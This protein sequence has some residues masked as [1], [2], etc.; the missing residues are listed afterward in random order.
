MAQVSIDSGVLT[1]RLSPADKFWALHGDIHLPIEHITGAAVEDENGWHYLWKLMG[2]S[3]PGIKVAGTFL[4]GG[5]LAFCDFGDGRNC[6]VLDTTHETYKKFVIELD[7]DQD[8]AQVA[9]QVNA[10]VAKP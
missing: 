7:P 4:T 9:R 8:A 10:L 6:L 2:T 1:I 5:D 3:M